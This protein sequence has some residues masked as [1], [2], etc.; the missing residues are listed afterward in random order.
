MIVVDIESTGVDPN[1]HCILSIGA[2]DMETG[3]TFYG[4]CCIYT[5]SEVS[6]RALEVNGFKAEDIQPGKKQWPHELYASFLSWCIALPHYTGKLLLA[7]HNPGH[8]DMLFLEKLHEKLSQA[9]CYAALAW[10][11]GYRSVDLHTLA[12]AVFGES[13]SHEDICKRLHFAPE[14]KPHNALLGAKSEAVCINYLLESIS[15]ERA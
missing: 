9:C 1:Q 13:L 11:F 12:F 2:V 4:E 8:M 5:D 6:P 10:P 15:N 14:P 3:L 7:G